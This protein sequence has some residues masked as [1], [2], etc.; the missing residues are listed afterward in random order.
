MANAFVLITWQKLAPMFILL[1]Q[2]KSI[3]WPFLLLSIALGRIL[4]I[5]KN[6]FMEILAYSS[7]FNLSWMLLAITIRRT[8]FM[9]FCLIYWNSV[10]LVVVF[11]KN[12]KQKKINAAPNS[13]KEKW[14]LILIMANLAGLPPLAGF[15]I[16]WILIK[17]VS[18]SNMLPIILLG[19]TLRR[20]NFFV[21][22][23]SIS[24]VILKNASQSQILPKQAPKINSTIFIISILFPIPL[25]YLLGHAWNKG[26]C[27]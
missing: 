5:D 27:W 10:L 13:R 11:L 3:I 8:L 9:V 25:I 12:S 19:L 24:K 15:M 2:V 17:E 18:V 23:R 26:L 20:I 4:Q 16:K 22:T 21:Y 14:I 7:V 6:L 1:Y